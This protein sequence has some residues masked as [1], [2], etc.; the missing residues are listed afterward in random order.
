MIR[1]ITFLTRHLV[2][3]LLLLT[4]HL[5]AH[6]AP[7]GNQIT[8]SL[9]NTNL[10]AVLAA[11]QKQSSYIFSFDEA[12]MQKIKVDEVSWK[13]VPLMKALATLKE[14]TGLDW[15]VLGNNIAFRNI[16]AQQQR[17]PNGSLRGRVVDF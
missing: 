2:I 6:A 3:G 5:C 9:K 4:Q 12:Q 14:K 17:Q 8:L 16:A 1:N 15:T 13:Q 11:M 7:P 10:A